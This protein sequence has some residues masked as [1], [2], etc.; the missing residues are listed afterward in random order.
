MWRVNSEASNTYVHK[1]GTIYIRASAYIQEGGAPITISV[2]EK[3]AY[4]LE[5]DIIRKKNAMVQH[6]LICL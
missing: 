1:Y 4:L 5:S 2:Q 3:Y 6:T